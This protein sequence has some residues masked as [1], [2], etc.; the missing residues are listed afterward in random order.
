M[1]VDDLLRSILVLAPR[2][3]LLEG[4][5]PTLDDY[6]P[7]YTP[8]AS[9]V[10]LVNG[11][12]ETRR[13]MTLW[14][15]DSNAGTTT[16]GVTGTL[17]GLWN[18][19]ESDGDRYR[20]VAIGG[21]LRQML[22]TDTAF[23][24]ATN[25]TGLASS[26]LWNGVTLADFF[27]FTDRVNSFKR[28]SPSAGVVVVA[29]PAAPSASPR[30]K[31][32][33]FGILD[34][35]SGVDPF[36]WTESDAS[37]FFV[38]A[39]GATDP[40]LPLSVPYNQSA[41]RTV[42]VTV[43]SS[44][45]KSDTI[46][47]NATYTLGSNT[48][49]FWAE[50]DKA[51]TLIQLQ[52]GVN[53]EGEQSFP[54]GPFPDIDEGYPFFEPIG[55]LTAI[56][57][58]RLRCR[59]TPGAD[60]KVNFSPLTLPGKLQ[61]L[62]RYVYT[63]Y[64]PSTGEES[65]PSDINDSGVPVDLSTIGVTFKPET[66]K[67]AYKCVMLDF[68]SDSGTDAATTKFRVYRNG[69]VPSL[70]KDSRGQD[71]WLRVAEI[72]DYST[73]LNGAASAAATSFVVD[74]EGN[75]AAGDWLVVDKGTSTEEYVKV[76]SVAST[77]INF[78]STPLQYAHSDNDT[79]QIA[80]LDNTS[81]QA[82]AGSVN[83][84][85]RERDNPPSAAHWVAK[86]PDGRIW[87]FRFDGKKMG[88]AVSNR[89]T[90]E[91]PFDHE[92]FP[93]GVNPLTRGHPLQGWR[94]D[95]DGDASGDEIVW[96]GFFNG[97]PTV[98]TRRGLWQID[99][100]S[101][102]Q[103][104]PTSVRKVLTEGCIAGETV[105]VL[106]DQL[107][108]VGEG[109]RLLRWDGRGGAQDLSYLR[110]TSTLKNAPT[111]YWGQWVARGQSDHNGSSYW[112]FMTPSGQTTNTKALRYTVG[113]E[114]WEPY[115]YGVP[116]ATA[117]VWDGPSD[118]REI[119]AAHPSSG[120]AYRL[121]VPSQVTDAGTA[122]ST[123]VKSKRFRFPGNVIGQV[124]RIWIRGLAASDTVS[125]TVT[126][127]GSEYGQVEATY[128]SLSFSGS[129][130]KE[131]VKRTAYGTLAGRWVQITLASSASNGVAPREV[132]IDYTVRRLGRLTI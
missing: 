120:N 26:S 123:S 27:Y 10:R 109:P 44:G 61:G 67:A 43:D 57:F 79:V 78:T 14:D 20:L 71:V 28:W 100:Y 73:Q 116:F 21:A 15:P 114:T 16:F 50:S 117:L 93:S 31:P 5:D 89:P 126:V 25:G 76:S 35:W 85:D 106:N 95:V 38:D 36:G 121:E 65:E 84:I 81:N 18:Y 62:Y 1:P 13:G 118:V 129:N 30:T 107:Y 111:A 77:T 83:V 86:A 91:R 69:G 45:S 110:L 108:W 19:Y 56:N 46:T 11:L 8:D 72:F 88:V 6:S 103:W 87:I 68:T 24:N 128:S 96:G 49:H 2:R 70:T 124:E 42:K 39:G 122:I 127:G 54:I 17:T 131:L 74:A 102:D 80:C 51:K 98:L 53:I 115:A 55:D 52:I 113:D 82:L 29:Q 97:V 47:K 112:L 34:G 3:G 48:I 104:S 60:K 99:A 66:A 64:D 130:D 92:V 7:E 33:V 75:I 41:L 105:Q 94:F 37:N 119:Y 58:L 132:G 32:W 23:S 125:V 101:Q 63:H 59:K 22:S 90:V 40:D 9:N 12:F 4:V